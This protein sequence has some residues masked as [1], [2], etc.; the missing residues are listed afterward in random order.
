MKT[1][2][3]RTGGGGHL[4]PFPCPAPEARANLFMSDEAAGTISEVTP[5]GAVSTFASG[6]SAPFGLA[7][8]TAGNLFVANFGGG[9]IREV[10]PG[11]GRLH[12]RFGVRRPVGLAFDA[13]RKPLRGQ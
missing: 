10:T 4:R 8:D 1:W 11:G 3:V 12:L 7:F 13:R 5:G 2:W 6:F 9:T